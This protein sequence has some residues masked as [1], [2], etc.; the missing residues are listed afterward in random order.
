MPIKKKIQ[1]KIK[2][3]R[4]NVYRVGALHLGNM[5][6]VPKVV[7]GGPT[8]FTKAHGLERLPAVLARRCTVGA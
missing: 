8:L 3:K 6:G 4:S 7:Q 5:A 1:K 2:L